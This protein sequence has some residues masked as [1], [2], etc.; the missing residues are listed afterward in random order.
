MRVG[1]LGGG[2][3][4]QMLILAGVPLGLKFVVFTPQISDTTRT[5]AEHIEAA[6]DDTAALD[7]F[8]DSVDVITYETESIPLTT[9]HY[10][11]KTKTV[12]PKST[13]IE[14]AQDR[15][16]EKELFCELGI[17]TNRY[18]TIDSADDIRKA[19][20]TLGLPFIIKSRKGGYDG[21]NQW[22]IMTDADLEAVCR[23]TLTD[24]LA[25]EFVQFDREVSVIAARDH[26]GDVVVYDICENVHTA[27][28]L[29]STTVQP[30]D[31][32]HQLATSYITDM[33]FRLD[34]V[35]V[36]T[37]EFFVKDN[38]LLANEMAPRVHNSGHWTIEGASTSQFEQHCRAICGWPLGMTTTMG[39]VAMVNLIG[40][41]PPPDRVMAVPYVTLHDYQKQLQPKRKL[42]HVTVFAPDQARMQLSLDR[43][44]SYVV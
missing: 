25:E 34:Y 18:C 36:L 41:M 44:F 19:K 33:L 40:D 42:G 7:Q 35:G 26:Q 13:A 1:I 38:A 23:E 20:E 21:K 9:V 28:I 3:L 2:Q 16:L 17:P 27:G 10:L 14:K 37:I 39:A 29:R 11:E 24:A 22:R 32:M 43:L 5:L 4:A 8:A 12:L 30:N 6:F 15:L 31:R